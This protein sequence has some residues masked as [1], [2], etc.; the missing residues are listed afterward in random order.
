MDKHE[1]DIQERIFLWIC[2]RSFDFSDY[3]VFINKPIQIVMV[4][5]NYDHNYL[6]SV[7]GVIG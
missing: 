2:N 3:A 5:E 7:F 4:L 1:F 6:N